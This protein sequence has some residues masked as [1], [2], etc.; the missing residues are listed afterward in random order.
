[1][2]QSRDTRS[3]RDAK[4]VR[5]L[6]IPVIPSTIFFPFAG[7]ASAAAHQSN[8]QHVATRIKV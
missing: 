5:A 8:A 2:K 6:T 7:V 3:A 1:M 4:A